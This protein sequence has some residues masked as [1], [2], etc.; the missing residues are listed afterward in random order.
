MQVFTFLLKEPQLKI[1][2]LYL[3]MHPVQTSQTDHATVPLSLQQRPYVPNNF[4]C[5][6][7][8]CIHCC[9]KLGIYLI[10]AVSITMTL[11]N[12]SCCSVL[13]ITQAL[14]ILFNKQTKK[15]N[16][17]ESQSHHNPNQISLIRHEFLF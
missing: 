12:P 9:R 13:T 1:Q 4:G 10:Q 15:K 5:L 6:K 16:T 11:K 14:Y 3:L 17:F 7:F 8:P 2:H